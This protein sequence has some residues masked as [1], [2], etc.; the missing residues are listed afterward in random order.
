MATCKDC[1][2]VDACERQLRSAFPNV[3][4]EEI[5]NVIIRDI[6][7]RNFKNKADIVE[8]VRCKDCFYF[9]DFG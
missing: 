1:F 3:L 4:D 9:K 7:C 2:H 6:N 8:V 5:K